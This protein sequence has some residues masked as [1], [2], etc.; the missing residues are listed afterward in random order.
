MFAA[1][2]DGQR[3]TTVEG[4]GGD[5]T[6]TPLQR[7]FSQCHALQCGFCTPG[8][9]MSATALLRKQPRPDEHA[10]RDLLAGHLCRCTGYSTIV[11][12]IAQA[13]DE[14]QSEHG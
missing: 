10:I 9:L 5:N 6:L 11:H 14:T 13:A 8:I 4:L 3:L 7:A 1:Q 2:V 12:A